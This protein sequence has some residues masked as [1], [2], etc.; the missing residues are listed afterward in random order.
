[1]K[2]KL[3]LAID[4]KADVQNAKR[5]VNHGEFVDW[6]LPLNF[7]YITSKK[8]FLSE[9]NKI[10]SEYTKHIH[11][12]NEKEIL[13]GVEETKKRWLKIECKFYSLV[14]KI[15]LGHDWPKG[16]YIGYVSI[17]LM[18][19]RNIKE[20]TFYFPYSNNKWNPI[21]TIAHEMLHFIFF[22]YINSKYKIKENDEF[23]DKNPKYVWQV[24]ETF[25]TVIENW[26]PYKNIVGSKDVKPYPGCEKMFKTMTKQW[27]ANQDI[28]SFLNK[29][30]LKENF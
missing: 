9:R 8:F 30:L 3:K 28:E 14:D 15:F 18:F 1:M 25:N 11:K 29:W 23:R 5:F 19:P 20:K 4:I 7:Q 12:M 21:S 10:I 26:Q 24:S 17:Y 16:K 6:F 2:P 27:S 22:D 13:K